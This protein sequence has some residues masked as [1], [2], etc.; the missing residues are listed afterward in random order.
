MTSL[1]DFSLLVVTNR[2]QFNENIVVQ[3]LK[4][5]VYLK[6][7]EFTTEVIIVTE[8]EEQ[9]NYFSGHTLL[10]CKVIIPN[11]DQLSIGHKRNLALTYFNGHYAGFIDDDD[12][13]PEYRFHLQ[14]KIL[15]FSGK[16][17][18]TTDLPLC[19][20]IQR[21]T[22]YF[23]NMV[24]ESTLFFKRAYGKSHKFTI[25]SLGEGASFTE[26]EE[27]AIFRD[28]DLIL[29]VDHKN[30]SSGQSR[31]DGD[32]ELFLCD[33]VPEQFFRTLNIYEKKLLERS[34]N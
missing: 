13:Y 32:S 1:I 5:I 34:S 25:N 18:T 28:H 31:V 20:S 24:C 10:N 23:A 12:I 14:F 29:A 9:I 27:V 16:S 4:Q 21:N 19:Y 30:N 8:N 15:A 3:C 2:P 17:V 26:G 11:K 6:K 7:R 33:S 22:S